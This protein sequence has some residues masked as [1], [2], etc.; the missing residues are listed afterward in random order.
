MPISSHLLPVGGLGM[1]FCFG[2][3]VPSISDRAKHNRHNMTSHMP[4]FKRND[5]LKALPI[6]AP[7]G[8]QPLNHSHPAR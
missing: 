8:W 2:A 5:A 4:H 6:L 3:I 7:A 1:A